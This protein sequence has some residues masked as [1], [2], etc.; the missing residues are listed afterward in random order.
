MQTVVYFNQWISSISLVLEDL[1][2]KFGDNIKIIASSRNKNHVYKNYVDEFIVEDWEEV[3]NNNALSMKNY[4]D[5]VLNLCKEKNVNIFFVKKHSLEIAKAAGS[6]ERLGI[7]LVQENIDTINTIENKS[8]TYDIIKNKMKDYSWLIPD[9]INTSNVKEL[10]NFIESKHK[11]NCE[12]CLKFNT[13]EGGASFRH[14]VDNRPTIHSLYNYRVNEISTT[15]TYEMLMKNIREVD[16]L[17][18][19]DMLDSPEISVDCY[20]SK[21]GFIAICREK[22]EGRVERIFYNNEIA[23]I[24][25]KI[26]EVFNLKYIYNVQFRRV[27]GYKEKYKNNEID[28]LRLLE[29]NPRMSGGVYMVAAY[30]MNLAEILLFDIFNDNDKYTMDKF[31]DF[32]DKYVTHLELPV[33]L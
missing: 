8:L 23:E 17:I 20:N 11:N 5:F 14:I 4:V 19:M 15:E 16:R 26:G 22:V 12:I 7:V 29:V 6:F 13:D 31:R 21:N 30:D 3:E 32:E 2:N 24:C 33:K 10:I 18:L 1:K 28:S 9:Y 25:R 27:H